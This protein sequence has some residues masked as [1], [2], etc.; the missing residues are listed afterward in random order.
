MNRFNC[1]KNKKFPHFENYSHNIKKKQGEIAVYVKYRELVSLI[2]KVKEKQ[3]TG[4]MGR[5][6]KLK[7]LKEEI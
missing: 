5:E 4:K 3:N 2:D 7:I 6:H 1:L